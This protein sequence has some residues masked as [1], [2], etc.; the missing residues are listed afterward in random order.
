MLNDIIE[1]IKL[2]YHHLNGGIKIFKL[3][4]NTK[5]FFPFSYYIVKSRIVNRD[6]LFIYLT[7]LYIL[8]LC[9]YIVRIGSDKS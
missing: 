4:S 5:L 6:F 1:N 8:C 9:V 3:P 7:I 2:I